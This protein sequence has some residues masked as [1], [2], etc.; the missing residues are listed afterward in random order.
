MRNVLAGLVMLLC[1]C[2]ATREYHPGTKFGP[3]QLQEDYKIFRE[4]L[5]ESHPSLYWYASKDSIDY[6]FEWGASKL[7]D[8]LQE[9][10]F[11]NV[12]SYVVSKF[13]CGHTS[14]RAS[15]AAARFA[16]RTRSYTF[17]L[18]IKTWPDTA[19]VTSNLNR[20]DSAVVRGSRVLSIDGR[21]MEMIL[22]SFFN[23][24]SA[25]G[26]NL[27]HKY[28]SV[29]NGGNFRTMYAYYFGLRQRMSIEYVDTLGNLKRG[30]IN[31]Y[32]PLRDHLSK[33]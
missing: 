29:S 25:D 9:Y 7:K 21:P 31:V 12:L 32:N 27:T 17:P 19:I 4:T 22:D 28:Q 3:K 33:Q 14:V 24:I 1:G 13:H 8:S 30:Y 11:R 10:Q 18:T 5:E 15:K 6:Y 23:H 16:E 2:A 26:Y 20:K